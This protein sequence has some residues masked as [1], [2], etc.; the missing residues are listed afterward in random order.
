[1]NTADER[2][3]APVPEGCKTCQYLETWTNLATERHR[4]IERFL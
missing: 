1:M 3:T 2:L 4:D